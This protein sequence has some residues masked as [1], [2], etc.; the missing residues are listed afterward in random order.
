MI[1]L[2]EV[3]M[4]DSD[5]DPMMNA[6]Q[7]GSEALRAALAQAEVDGDLEAQNAL[8]GEL[9][10]ALLAEDETLPALACFEQGLKIAQQ[11]D[12]KQSGARHLA[13]QGL[14]L[15]QIG[16]YALAMRAFRKAYGFAREITDDPLTFE[17]LLRMAEL[18]RARKNPESAI[19]HLEEALAIANQHRSINRALRVH[20]EHGQA[21]WDLDETDDAVEHFETALRLAR[22][23]GDVAAQAHCLNTLGAFARSRRA[24]NEAAGYFADV[25]ALSPGALSKPQRLAA[26]AQLGDIRFSQGEIEASRQLFS[27]GLTIAT[28][29]GDRTSECRLLGSLGLI[30][31]D[32]D[33]PEEAL[34]LAHQSVALA[35]EL[36]DARLQGE[37]LLYLSMALSDHG[38]AEEALAAC[39]A[40]ITFFEGIEASSHVQKAYELRERLVGDPADDEV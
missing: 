26:L 12:D 34:R 20:L 8:Q 17:L 36:S 24:M 7:Q 6:R 33:D 19:G 10:R 5:V 30:A 13:N 38:D 4:T 39:D 40:A 21:S 35:Q 32:L 3:A 37:Q 29:L 1:N 9:G 27:E 15:G 16:N 28:G 25:L 18:E 23:A 11:L 14:A 22:E 31:A 2:T